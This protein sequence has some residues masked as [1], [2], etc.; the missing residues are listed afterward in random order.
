[1]KQEAQEY[2]RS[3]IVENGMLEQSGLSHTAQRAASKIGGWLEKHPN[4]P[5]VVG[6]VGYIG[7]VVVNQILHPGWGVGA[8]VFSPIFFDV[9]PVDGQYTLNSLQGV[10]Q[11]MFVVGG[12]TGVISGV[13]R[14][15][16]EMF[17]SPKIIEGRAKNPYTKMLLMVDHTNELAEG[18]VHGDLYNEFYQYL[19]HQPSEDVSRFI[20]RYGPVCEIVPEGLPIPAEEPSIRYFRSANPANTEFLQ[21][22]V[23]AKKTQGT[24]S[25]LMSRSHTVWDIEYSPKQ[26]AVATINNM[27]ATITETL[28]AGNIPKIV[29]TN[30]REIVTHG[31]FDAVSGQTR[32]D[33]VSA[34]EYFEGQGYS[35]LLAEDEVMSALIASFQHKDL[36]RIVLMDDGTPEGER[37]ADNWLKQYNELKAKNMASSFPEILEVPEGKLSTVLTTRDYDGIFLIG[38]E[39]VRVAEAARAIVERQLSDL[40]ETA[41]YKKVPLEVLLEGRGFTDQL[42]HVTELGGELHFVHEILAK[43]VFSILSE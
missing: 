28:G 30:N 31:A 21:T 23:N 18:S 9:S 37:I 1:M 24:I 17:Y 42:S 39:D 33:T 25:V 34:R 3:A 12:A 35:V 36:K 26:E 16:N 5:L 29:V 10:F 40:T 8:N 7:E 14:K 19:L 38:A 6:S 27:N 20:R 32:I 43:R 15:V 2:L 22:L 4:A 11:G 41:G 13:A